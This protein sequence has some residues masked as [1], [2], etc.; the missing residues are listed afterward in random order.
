V[1][2]S[3]KSDKPMKIEESNIKYAQ[4]GQKGA[5]VSWFSYPQGNLEP[6]LKLRVPKDAKVE[7]E[8][9]ATFLDKPIPITCEGKNNFFVYRALITRKLK[10]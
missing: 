9:R 4:R 2:L 6:K 1:S 10:L 3:L 5:T 8:L 7:A